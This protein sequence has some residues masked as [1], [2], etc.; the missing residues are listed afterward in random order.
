M[1]FDK[2]IIKRRVWVYGKG[3]DV[4]LVAAQGHRLGGGG[5]RQ[6]NSELKGTSLTLLH[7]AAL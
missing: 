1:L 3:S 6:P 2:L 7:A 4:V 5:T